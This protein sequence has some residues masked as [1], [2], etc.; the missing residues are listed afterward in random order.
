[1]RQI[2]KFNWDNTIKNYWF[3]NLFIKNLG[4]TKHYSPLIKCI[5]IAKAVFV[6]R[7][8]FISLSLKN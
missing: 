6:A 8:I 2:Y 7:L 1:M 5:I 4:I 3:Y